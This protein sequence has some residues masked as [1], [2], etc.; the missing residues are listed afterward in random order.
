MAIIRDMQP[1]IL[2]EKVTY[3]TPSKFLKEVW[4]EIKSID[5]AIYENDDRIN[6]QSV[7]FNSSTHT[8][9]TNYKEIKE[10]RNRIRKGEVIYTILSCKTRGRLTTLL[11]KVVDTDV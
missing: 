1:Y 7:R 8:G 3:R 4:I 2:E 10:G 9:L 6:T 11:L 5:V